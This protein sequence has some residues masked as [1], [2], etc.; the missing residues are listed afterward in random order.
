MS[1][2][3]NGSGVEDNKRSTFPPS[4]SP[5]RRPLFDGVEA[6]AFSLACRITPDTGS[7]PIRDPLL[8]L[9][10]P[11]SGLV[12]DWTGTVLVCFALFLL[13]YMRRGEWRRKGGSPT[14]EAGKGRG[15][16]GDLRLHQ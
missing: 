4:A 9:S 16:A 8:L 14:S 3:L 7:P 6:I 13:E 2:H 12:E 1:N 15:A 5:L 11:V 10:Y